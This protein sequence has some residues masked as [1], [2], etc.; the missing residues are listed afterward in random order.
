MAEII[1]NDIVI[2]KI[3]VKKKKPWKFLKAMVWK[4]RFH[5]MLILKVKLYELDGRYDYFY[6]QMAYSTG[7]I[8]ALI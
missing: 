5:A 7:I 1:N 4:I 2:N 8:K 3:K 6:G